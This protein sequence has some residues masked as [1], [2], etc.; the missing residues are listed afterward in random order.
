MSPVLAFQSSHTPCRVLL[1]G[2]PPF[3]A[4]LREMLADARDIE[5]V[6]ADGVLAD[7]EKELI[8]YISSSLDLEEAIAKKIVDKRLSHFKDESEA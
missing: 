6:L 2:A 3:V 7:K 4:S 1:V 5:L 8:S